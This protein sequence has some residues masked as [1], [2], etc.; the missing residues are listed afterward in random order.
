M[1]IFENKGALDIRA[2]KT[3]GVSS[4][5]NKQTAIGYFGTGLKYA[6]AILLRNKHRISIITNG[7]HFEF[8]TIQTK[9]RNDDFE[10]VRMNSE[11]LGFT[12]ELGKDW[13]LW[14]AFRELY[15]N[16]LDEHGD[17]REANGIALEDQ[18]KTYILVHGD[19]FAKIFNDRHKY[20]LPKE[21]GKIEASRNVE[22][23]DK[24]VRESYNQASIYYKGVRVMLTLQNSIYDYNLL[25]GLTLTED[26][27]IKVSWSLQ[28]ELTQAVVLS[29]NKKL[30][31]T[32][33][34]ANNGFFEHSLNYSLADSI[35]HEAGVFLE[36][37]GQLRKLHSD[38][39]LN[40][41]AVEFHKKHT[42]TP[43]VLP[44][45]SCYLDHVEQQQFDRAVTFCKE[46]L[47]LE[48]DDYRIII[49][50]DL[51]KDRLGCADMDASIMYISKQ[52]FREGTKRVAV[53]LLEEYTHC[54]H[55][56]MDETLEQKWVY[57]NQILSLGEQLQGQP[58]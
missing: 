49:A 8:D 10:I 40:S 35:V 33:V 14:M 20:F 47:R 57:L 36:V 26:R 18:D 44:S 13:E 4:K 56:V 21:Y 16:M 27:T 46:T 32:M 1:I 7:V 23:L 54:K 48:L 24:T 55:R 34:M 31:T 28:W 19:P 9:I 6:I 45:I 38:V 30:I 53:A 37:V 51:G 52:C 17:A 29:K 41:T 50:K 42:S 15:S 39:G 5:E 12:T 25:S 2:I 43:T 3:F 11:E 58:L 22:F